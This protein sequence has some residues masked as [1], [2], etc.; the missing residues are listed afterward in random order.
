MLLISNTVYLHRQLRLINRN[1][2]IS[3]V[4]HIIMCIMQTS[5]SKTSWMYCVEWTQYS[6]R[7]ESIRYIQQ[8][9][10]M[11]NPSP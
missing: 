4:H 11:A 6:I 8:V 3:N 7:S 1:S 5:I 9:F 2:R 10:H